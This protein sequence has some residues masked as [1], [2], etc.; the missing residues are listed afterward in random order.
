MVRSSLLGQHTWLCA[1]RGAK[2]LTGQNQSDGFPTG[3]IEPKEYLDARVECNSYNAIERVDVH[4]AAHS[5]LPMTSWTSHQRR[6]C[7]ANSHP[8]ER[9][10]SLP[11]VELPTL[12]R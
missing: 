8:P 10:P 3:T 6:V 1:A 4:D 5:R 2:R 11:R 7:T 9:A 12:T